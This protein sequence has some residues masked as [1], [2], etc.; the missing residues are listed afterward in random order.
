MKIENFIPLLGQTVWVED[1]VKHLWDN[2]G[3][4]WFEYKLV[5]IDLKEEKQNVKNSY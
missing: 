5:G 2:G 3:P 1:H 4:I